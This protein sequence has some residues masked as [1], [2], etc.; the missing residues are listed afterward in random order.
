M[1]QNALEE[2]VQ[3]RRQS[4]PPPHVL[5]LRMELRKRQPQEPRVDVEVN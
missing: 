5:N 3:A 2:P 1:Y 4:A